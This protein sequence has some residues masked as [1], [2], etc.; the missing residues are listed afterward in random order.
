MRRVDLPRLTGV[1]FSDTHSEIILRAKTVEGVLVGEI[2]AR[3]MTAATLTVK[4]S[5]YADW[6]VLCRSVSAFLKFPSSVEHSFDAFADWLSDLSWLEPGL[7]YLLVD[8][9]ELDKTDARAFDIL[10][11]MVGAIL[12]LNRYPRLKLVLVLLI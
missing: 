10:D 8:I 7:W 6:P 12:E 1:A 2:A 5:S 4:L 11:S 3:G 9:S